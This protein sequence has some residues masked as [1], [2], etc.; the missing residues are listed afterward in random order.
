MPV[1]SAR[2][3]SKSY[4]SKTLF[5]D[6][7]LT[8]RRGEKVGL[9]GRNGAGKSSFLRVIAGLEAADHGVIEPRRDASIRYLSQ[10]PV[11]D[12]EKT[13]REIVS[14]S[15]PDGR[16]YEADAMLDRVGIR[17]EDWDRKVGGFSGGERRRVALAEILVRQPDLAILDEPTNHLDIET[18]T[19]LEEHLANSFPGA[20]LLVSHDRYV[21]DAI[22]DRIVELAGGELTEYEGN[23]G[24]YLEEKS[25]RD[26]H[27]VRVEQNRQNLLRRERAWL[28]R[29]AKA[30]S[31]KQK[32]RIQRAEKLI[33]GGPKRSEGELD[34]SE[35]KNAAPRLGKTIL[36]FRDVSLSIGERTLVKDLT[37]TLRAGE[38]IGIIGPNGAGKTTLLKA[39]ADLSK[40]SGGEIVRGINTSLVM[41]DQMRSQLE[42]DW[43][44]YDN[45][46]EREGAE[47][48]GGGMVILGERELSLRQYLELFLFEGSAQRK[49]VSA[50]SGGERARVA[51]AKALRHGSNLLI[52]DEPTNDLDVD[53]LSA[54]EELLSG[55][56]GVV[57]VV[58]HDRFFLDRVTTSILA[59]QP[60]ATMVHHAGNYTD[61]VDDL[62]RRKDE[63]AAA[64]KA[65]KA[66]ASAPPAGGAKKSEAPPPPVPVGKALTYAERLELDTMMDVI[67]ARE[68]IVAGLE[69]K[70]ADPSLWSDRPAEAPKLQ[71]SLTH[72]QAE[73]A[74]LS[75]RWEDLESRKDIKKK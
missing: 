30:R 15:L 3:V 60:D 23:Y 14:E 25:I 57:L 8:V 33:A 51:L 64:E 70:L 53:T 52:L 19:W 26:E 24:D 73:V 5:E 27:G 66:K 13:A 38:R 55:W 68:E 42:D 62:A 49:K 36:D 50:L 58:S 28:A 29:G 9:L 31:T 34:F 22:A 1:I 40:P 16:E 21:L 65:R 67:L 75:A 12:D 54:L 17:Y 43:S 63:A 72:A 69:K 37:L 46:A 56:P 41:F 32:A 2:N 74:R 4:G 61:Y 20:V 35:L 7:S 10:E 59:I 18:I 6:I 44:I 11:L 39:A 45:V 47:R 71:A 48:T